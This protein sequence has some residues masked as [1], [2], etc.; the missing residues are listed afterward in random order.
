MRM[1]ITI[2]HNMSQLSMTKVRHKKPF[3]PHLG[4]TYELVTEDYRMISE[5][6]SHHPPISAYI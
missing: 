3:N 6:V 5:Q 4:E 1:G 2:G